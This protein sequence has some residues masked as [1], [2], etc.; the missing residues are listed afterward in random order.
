MKIAKSIIEELNLIKEL[1]I[2]D[3]E[4]EKGTSLIN[5]G[6]SLDT[7]RNLLKGWLK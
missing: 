4:I 3:Q 2:I 7:L 6:H 1:A 5:L